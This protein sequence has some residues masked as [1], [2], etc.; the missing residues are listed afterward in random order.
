[1]ECSKISDFIMKYIDGDISEVE[2]KMLNRHMLCCEECSRELQIL[3]EM[4]KCI[5]ELPEIEAPAGLEARVM[6]R[7]KQQ[8]SQASMLN[9]LMGAAGL[10]VFAYYMTI[11]AILPFFR[12]LGAFQMILSYGSYFLKLIGEYLMKIIVYLPITIENLLILRNILVR[13][14]MNIMLFI[15]GVVMLLNLEL[16]KFINLQQE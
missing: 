15:A 1:M 4:S 9:M 5:S 11:F 6:A 8:R 10:L 2:L 7:I 14:Y 16:I 13:D 3:T 12:E